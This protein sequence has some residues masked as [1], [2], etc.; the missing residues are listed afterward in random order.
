[1]TV[2]D[3]TDLYQ[4]FGDDR[5]PPGQ[6]E[7]TKFPVLSKGDTPNWDR[8]TWTFTVTGA[9]DTELSLSYDEFR[10]LDTVTQRQDF[11]CVTGWSKLDC[12]F[13]GVPFPELAAAAGVTDDAVHVLFHAL[14]GYTTNLPLADCMREEVLFTWAFDDDPL[15]PEHGGPLRVVTPHKYAYKGA[16]WV[17]GVEFLTEPQ[18]GY[19]E[20]RGYSNTADPW[21]EDRYS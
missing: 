18:R 15:P 1:M 11:H 13:T 21:A 16:K 14:D 5:I 17:D 2:E 10:A 3:V 7:T 4:A 20:K 9:V 6:R 12:E 8:D 19:W